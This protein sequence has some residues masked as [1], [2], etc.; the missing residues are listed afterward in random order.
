M[1][2]WIDCHFKQFVTYDLAPKRLYDKFTKSIFNVDYTQ[3]R[4][5][6]INMSL[7]KTFKDFYNL[8]VEDQHSNK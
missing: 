3:F 6:L 8:F 4:I 1:A 2:N 5:D 7:S